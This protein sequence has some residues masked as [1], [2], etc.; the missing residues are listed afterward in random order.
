MRIYDSAGVAVPEVLLPKQGFDPARW[1]VVAC[2]QYT[3]QP[4]YWHEVAQT[5]GDAPSTLNLI[6]PEVYLGETEPEKRIEGI[7]R[8]M[9]EYLDSGLLVGHDG[10]VYV[11]RLAGG[12]VRRGVVL[13]VDLERYDYSKGS[14][15]LIRATEGTIVERLPP[16]IKIRQGAP[17]EL[18]HIMILIDDPGNTVIGPLTEGKASMPKVYDFGLML[19]AGHL[20]G[21]L[22][23]DRA[24]ELSLVRA[25]EALG[26]PDTFRKKYDVGTDTPVLLYAMGDGNH[27]LAT[28]KAIWEKTKEQAA[29]VADVMTSP[30]RYALV[31]IVNLHDD[32]LIFEPI[33]RVVFDV[34]EGTDLLGELT[35]MLEGRIAL[36]SVASLD[37]MKELVVG[38][39]AERQRFGVLQQ[40]GYSVAEVTQADHNLPVGTL[41]SFLDPFMKAG[42]AK[43]IDYVH[44][45][46]PVD[47]LGRKPGNMGFFLPSMSKHD[48]FRSVILD[49]ALPRKTFSMGE[50]EEKRFYM[51]CR[52]LTA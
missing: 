41:Q 38:S 21:Y 8:S 39:T 18:P 25:L 49:G 40:S 50:A 3:S 17:L 35:A 12:R 43:E 9:R 36:Q 42:K 11:E 7:R 52:R 32:S 33:H 26:N 24:M 16:R 6:Y 10:I 23:A 30:T 51:E 20:A 47:E 48:L 2:D 45:T 31:E 4:A 37:D 13:C 29:R 46:G 5:V 1:A 44:G 28:A 34:K 22:V 19:G 27:S 14:S 15:S